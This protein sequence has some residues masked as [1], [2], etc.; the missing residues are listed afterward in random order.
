M[1]VEEA[2]EEYRE[3][4]AKFI[5]ET[6]AERVGARDLSRLDGIAEAA[7]HAEAL[8]EAENDPT[9]TLGTLPEAQEPKPSRD[10]SDAQR[11][12]I[13]EELME[14]ARNAVGAGGQFKP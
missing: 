2:E 11:K 7:Q 14:A 12:A 9:G 1:A 3:Q 13:A 10:V 5:A 8:S 4:M 6:A